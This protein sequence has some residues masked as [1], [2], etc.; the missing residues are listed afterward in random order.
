MI[1]D[2]DLVTEDT[3]E[4]GIEE[5]KRVVKVMKKD[6]KLLKQYARKSQY[7][8]LICEK[9]IHDILNGLQISDHYDIKPLYEK[10]ELECDLEIKKIL[11]E[12]YERLPPVSTYDSRRMNSLSELIRDDTNRVSDD[13]KDAIN[14]LSVTSIS[15]ESKNSFNGSLD[16]FE[17]SLCN[18][19][20]TNFMIIMTIDTQWKIFDE[21]H[22]TPQFGLRSP[23]IEHLLTTWTNDF[24]KVAESSY[25]YFT[26][27]IILHSF[28]HDFG[29]AEGNS[30]FFTITS[31]TIAAK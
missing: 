19:H 29:V 27:V 5:Y 4:C 17:V 2:V 23:V 26:V 30:S 25:L 22:P 18:C 1:H 10:T 15:D 11:A 3:D 16:P 24:S 31:S 6:M 8:L 7:Q 14:Y 20:I 21:L 9:F 13:G 12:I 28:G